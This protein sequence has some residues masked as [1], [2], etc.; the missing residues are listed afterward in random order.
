M[1]FKIDWPLELWFRRI[2]RF[3]KICGKFDVK[4]NWPKKLNIY[5]FGST[6]SSKVMA[7]YAGTEERFGTLLK[8]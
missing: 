4:S 8:L 3:F 6:T 1:D 7:G 2:G 5:N